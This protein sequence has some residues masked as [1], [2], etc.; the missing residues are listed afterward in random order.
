MKLSFMKVSLIFL[1]NLYYGVKMSCEDG[2]VK[3]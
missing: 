2:K 1:I 3:M